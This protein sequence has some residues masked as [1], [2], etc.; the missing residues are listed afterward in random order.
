MKTVEMLKEL[1]LKKTT[2]TNYALERSRLKAEFFAMCS[3]YLKSTEQILVFTF[4]SQ[5]DL[6]TFID[7]IEDEDIQ[8]AYR[9]SQEDDS[10][11]RVEQKDL[12]IVM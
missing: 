12:E 2:S 11:F 6:S 7:I 9:V 1:M 5:R 4:S 10:I 8:L 3:K